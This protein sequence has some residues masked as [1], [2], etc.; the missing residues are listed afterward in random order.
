MGDRRT[1]I[2]LVRGAPDRHIITIFDPNY[3]ALLREIP[4]PPIVL[5]AQGNFNAVDNPQIAIVGSRKAS[6]YGLDAAFQFA[7]MLGVRGFTITSG[8]AA[9]IDGSA[10]R[11]ALANGSATVAVYGCGIDRVYPRRHRDL[12]EEIC[13]QGVVISEFPIGSPPRP[14]HFPHRNR[15][16]SGLSFGT[17]VVE[18]AAKSGSI[19]TAIHALEQG[20]EVFALPGSIR[21]PLS[22]GCHQLIKQGATMV[23]EINDVIDQLPVL[24][25]TACSTSAMLGSRNEYR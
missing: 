2:A 6:H 14:Y 21:N 3:P 1:G 5:F 17:L 25:V 15:I 19:S 23:T 4:A 11:G 22:A 7:R 20:R 18:A 12:A 9:G 16:I 10:H 8:L 13:V 24:S